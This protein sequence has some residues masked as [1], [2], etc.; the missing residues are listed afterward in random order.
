MLTELVQLGAGELSLAKTALV[1]RVVLSGRPHITPA[2]IPG[3]LSTSAHSSL[4]P[5]WSTWMR[6]RQEILVAIRR[7]H[8][9][10]A[11]VHRGRLSASG[12]ATTALKPPAPPVTSSSCGCGQAIAAAGGDGSQPLHSIIQ[13]GNS[14]V[15]SARGL[16]LAEG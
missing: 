4:G 3:A 2:T 12:A 5:A 10:T 14:S 15:S 8:S 11:A 6:L 9:T 7:E 16:P 1:S 13:A